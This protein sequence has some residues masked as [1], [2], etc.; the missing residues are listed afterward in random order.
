MTGKQIYAAGWGAA[1]LMVAGLVLCFSSPSFGIKK[2]LSWL[3]S[4]Q[5]G[6]ADSSLYTA[7][8]ENNM[9]MFITL[10]SI[11]FAAGL[12]S[13]I[14]VYFTVMIRGKKEDAIIIEPTDIQP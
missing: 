11:L 4:Q 10:G 5:D 3:Q 2:A 1:L 9:A 12:L 14:G 6:M 7:V 8:A 13:A